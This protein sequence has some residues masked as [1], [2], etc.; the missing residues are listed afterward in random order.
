VLLAGFV[1]VALLRFGAVPLRRT[2]MID[3]APEARH[4]SVRFFAQRDSV[5]ITAPADMSVG[6]LIRLYH[7][8]NTRGVREAI[9]AQLGVANDADPVAKGTTIRL[10]LTVPSR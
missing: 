7:L 5:L 9:Q 10:H 1:G 3:E 6:E 4:E 2:L 8:R